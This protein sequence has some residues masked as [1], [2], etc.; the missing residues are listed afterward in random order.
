M[1]TPAIEMKIW[2]CNSINLLRSYSVLLIDC[3]ALTERDGRILWQMVIMAFDKRIPVGINWKIIGSSAKPQLIPVSAINEI[4]RFESLLSVNQRH[5]QFLV[6]RNHSAFAT[7]EAVSR[8]SEP[9]RKER[10]SISPNLP[11]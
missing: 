4:N 10:L 11:C 8:A 2:V 9:I 5:N 7:N 1:S 6:S 3:F